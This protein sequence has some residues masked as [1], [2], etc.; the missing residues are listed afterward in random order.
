MTTNNIVG[1]NEYRCVRCQRKNTRPSSLC[2]TCE[3][4]QAEKSAP[5]TYVLIEEGCHIPAHMKCARG[6]CNK[7]G[8]F[9][10]V[11]GNQWYCY[12][13]KHF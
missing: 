2:K 8:S 1:M 11:N 7:L 12:D 13:H 3:K 4:E 10:M 5:V 6:G 9:A